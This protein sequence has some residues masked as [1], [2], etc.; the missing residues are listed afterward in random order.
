MNNNNQL[1]E[2]NKEL[3]CLYE[4]DKLSSEAINLDEYFYKLIKIIQNGFQYISFLKVEVEYKG[5]K[6]RSENFIKTNLYLQRDIEVGDKIK[7]SVTVY[8]FSPQMTKATN[9]LAEEKRLMY[10]VAARIGDY[11]FK[12]ENLTEK[13]SGQSKEEQLTDHTEIRKEILEKIMKWINPDLLGII[14]IYIIG[15]TKNHTAAEKSDIDLIIYHNGKPENKSKISA[16]FSGWESS[17][18]EYEPIF[19]NIT[20]KKLFDLHFITDE[21]IKN[22]TSYAV[23]IGS[24]RN[25]A[26]LL[27]KST[28]NN[29]TQ[30]D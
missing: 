12:Y 26:K 11:L 9:F 30:Y 13:N 28:K 25:S 2:R 7:A 24:H 19:N 4:I 14:A 3:V 22:K 6:Y 10:S 27:L 5:R 20:D 18:F 8:Y 1:I 29:L 17:I 15:S 16:W 21:D 23:M